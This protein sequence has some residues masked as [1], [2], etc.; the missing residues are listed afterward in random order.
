MGSAVLGL[1]WLRLSDA[2]KARIWHLYG[3]FC[4]SAF[5]CSVFGMITW[6]GNMQQLLLFYKYTRDAAPDNTWVDKYRARSTSNY[7]YAAHILL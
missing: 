3:R 4:L 6:I 2:A 7:W 1:L 5:M